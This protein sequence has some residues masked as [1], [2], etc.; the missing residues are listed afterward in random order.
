MEWSSLKKIHPE[1]VV[2]D[3]PSQVLSISKDGDSTTSL[4]AN[5]CVKTQVRFRNR[6]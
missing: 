3:Q 2:Q 1:L 4:Y 6:I 5:E